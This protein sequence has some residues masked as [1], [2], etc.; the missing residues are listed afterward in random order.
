MH[1]FKAETVWQH[2][3]ACLRRT[4][5]VSRNYFLLFLL[6]TSFVKQ[7]CQTMTPNEASFLFFKVFILKSL[8]FSKNWNMNRVLWLYFLFPQQESCINSADALP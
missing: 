7:D 2:P 1:E 4:Y 5:C 8:F 6:N 3:A